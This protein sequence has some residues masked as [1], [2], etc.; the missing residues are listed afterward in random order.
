MPSG[1]TRKRGS[2]WTWYIEDLPDPSTGRPPPGLQGRLPDQKASPRRPPRGP[3]G[4]AV[5]NVRGAVQADG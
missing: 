3:G 4:P 2:T 5:R 1:W